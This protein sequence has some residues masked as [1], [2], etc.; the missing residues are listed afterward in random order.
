MRH[1]VEGSIAGWLGFKGIWSFLSAWKKV[2]E[3]GM[4][5]V[6]RPV[7]YERQRER[8]RRRQRH[9]HRHYRRKEEG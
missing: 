7:S 8:Q 9:K 1:R 2:R 3:N 6:G 5:L 4:T